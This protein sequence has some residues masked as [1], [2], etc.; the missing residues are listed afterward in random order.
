MDTEEVVA[1][2]AA[3]V[4]EVTVEAVEA[5]RLVPGPARLVEAAFREAA[6]GLRP[7]L[8]LAVLVLL[9][10][11]GLLSRELEERVCVVV[12]IGALPLPP[13]LLVMMNLVG[14]C[15]WVTVW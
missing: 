13:L 1:L 5:V 3:V 10:S 11:T 12:A 14:C 7:R 15:C 6:L 4:V 2:A 8:V 9:P